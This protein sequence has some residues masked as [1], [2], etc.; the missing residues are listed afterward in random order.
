MRENIAAL[1][2]AAGVIGYWAMPHAQDTLRG[3]PYVIDGDTIIVNGTHVR[4]AA[5]DAPET[6]QTCADATGQAYRCGLLAASALE[7]E[8]AGRSVTCTQ[9]DTDKYGRVVA[10]CVIGGLDL[11]EFMVR[12]GMAVDYTRYDPEGKYV[13][14]QQDAKTAGRGIWQGA[15]TEPE[16][17]RHRK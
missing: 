3:V 7:Q 2:V 1:A 6:D 10:Y 11:G 15:F 13:E 17:W 9:T 4:L 16:I 5:I 8:I 14:A 12:A